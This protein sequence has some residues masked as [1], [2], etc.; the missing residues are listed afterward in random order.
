[1]NTGWGGDTVVLQKKDKVLVMGRGK[2][3]AQLPS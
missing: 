1:M 2:V 3:H